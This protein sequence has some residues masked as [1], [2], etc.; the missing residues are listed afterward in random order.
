MTNQRIRLNEHGFIGWFWIPLLLLGFVLAG[1]DQLQQLLAPLPSEDDETIKIGFIYTT[2]N[3]INSRYGAELATNELNEEGGV[4]GTPIQLVAHGIPTQRLVSENISDTEYVA[5]IAEELITEEGVTA[6]AGP[7]RST[8][9][10]IVGEIAQRHG[11]PMITT[12]ATN[13]SVTA[14][15]DFVFMAAFTDDFQGKVMA[16]FAVQDLEAKSA[17][18]LTHAGDVYSEGL[19]KT[20][21]ANFTAYGGEVVAEQFYTWRATPISPPS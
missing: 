9:A 3:R 4:R 18:V 13:P 11:I 12:G 19:S 7:N 1:C 2:P 17:A 21:I 15:G 10:V 16:Q 6:I 5:G 20:F 14:A 8:H